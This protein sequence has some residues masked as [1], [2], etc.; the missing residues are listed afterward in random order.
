M[1]QKACMHARKCARAHL[2]LMS[3]CLCTIL[4]SVFLLLMHIFQNQLLP[5][6]CER[7]LSTLNLL[8]RKI[9]FLSYKWGYRILK[10]KCTQLEFWQF[11]FS[12]RFLC[13]IWNIKI[14]HSS[15]FENAIFPIF[16]PPFPSQ[17]AKQLVF[18]RHIMD[19]WAISV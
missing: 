16:K 7:I 13:T 8:N 3:A 19:I 2:L 18:D 17:G 6:N 12:A 4:I 9:Y 15:I 5:W 1:I 14:T 10:S 11:Y